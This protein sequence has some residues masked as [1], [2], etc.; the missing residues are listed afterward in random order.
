MRDAW[1]RAWPSGVRGYSFPPNRAIFVGQ[2]LG[3]AMPRF[4]VPGVIRSFP[5]SMERRT[6]FDFV[7]QIPAATFAF[8]CTA[9]FV[10]VMWLGIIFLKPVFRLLVGNEPGIN[11]LISHTT[12]GFSL[13]YGL[14]LGLL[15]VAAYQN[16]E[17]VSDAVFQEAADLATLY[18]NASNYPEPG[19][20][21]ILYL[22][23]D[24][25]LYT[26]HKD[27]PAHQRGEIYLGGGSRMAVILRK[28]LR[29]EPKTNSAEI[30]QRQ[31]LQ[32]FN[33]L[34]ESRQR[35][36]AGVE[37]R[38]PG[39]LW[40]VVAIGAVINIVLIW[41][42]K[43]RFFTHIVLGGIVAFFLGIVIFLVASMDNPLRGE[44]SVSSAPYLKV[45]EGIMQWDD[46]YQ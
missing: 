1:E 26:I 34:M 43:M 5:S 44:I 12:S 18:R 46:E 42:L 37:T 4:A 8:F 25:T 29:F 28:L 9:F 15:S 38:I 36:L 40:F 20:S 24:Y 30:L 39:V 3:A 21:E 32:T 45:Y 11:G 23:R 19:R 14:L 16:Y 41:M 33:A 22:L 27:W 10:L 13:F 35:R 6:M 7:Y 17:K 31:M 2:G